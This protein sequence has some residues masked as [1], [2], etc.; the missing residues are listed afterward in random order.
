MDDLNTRTT[1]IPPPQTNNTLPED[2]NKRVTIVYSPRPLVPEVGGSDAAQNPAPLPPLP[3]PSTP[4]TFGAPPSNETDSTRVSVKYST[5]AGARPSSTLPYNQGQGPRAVRRNQQHDEWVAPLP[6]E[7]SPEWQGRRRRSS[8]AGPDIRDKR[9]SSGGSSLS[10]LG[11]NLRRR[12]SMKVKMTRKAHLIVM[13]Q[14][15]W[16]IVLSNFLN[17]LL[18]AVDFGFVGRLGEDELAGAR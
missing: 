15:T 17:F 6:P 18:V 12:T 8:A 5:H 11:A 4:R 3:T 16:P 13:L 14:L 7:D 1:S 10:Q 9:R 2:K